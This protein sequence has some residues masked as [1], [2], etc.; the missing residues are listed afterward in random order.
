M[1]LRRKCLPFSHTFETNLYVAVDVKGDRLVTW[2]SPRL[3]SRQS[4]PMI[5]HGSF[6]KKPT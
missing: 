5:H 2:V 3:V 1:L 6:H 4:R